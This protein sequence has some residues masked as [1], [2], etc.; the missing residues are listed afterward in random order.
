MLLTLLSKD[1]RV[2]QILV[3][4][5]TSLQVKKSDEV[6]LVP[7]YDYPVVLVVNHAVRL[8][9]NYRLEIISLERQSSLFTLLQAVAHRHLR[10]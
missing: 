10:Y 7:T 4:T 3:R 1:T 9:V 8:L 2:V 5:L 6:V